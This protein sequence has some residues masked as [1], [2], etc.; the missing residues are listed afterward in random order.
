MT[1][2]NEAIEA[3]REAYI[4]VDCARAGDPLVAAIEAAFS[5]L[6]PQQRADEVERVARAI[7]EYAR[8]QP[9]GSKIPRWEKLTDRRCELLLGEARAAI[10][11]MNRAPQRTY[12]DGLRRAAQIARKHANGNATSAERIA[13]GSIVDEIAAELTRSQGEKR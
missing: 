6:V 8:A 11:A 9:E 4:R 12:E 5:H 13:A 7:L 10:A 1:I 3:A 2:P